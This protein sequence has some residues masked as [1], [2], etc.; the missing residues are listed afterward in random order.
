MLLHHQ[1]S[2]TCHHE[3]QL[4][5]SNVLMLARRWHAAGIIV[6]TRNSRSHLPAYW[7]ACWFI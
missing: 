3:E 7:N 2:K 1:F 5:E 6:C 4:E